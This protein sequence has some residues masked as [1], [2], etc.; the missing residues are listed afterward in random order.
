MKNL[1]YL[2]GLLLLNTSIFAQ[3]RDCDP[4]VLKGS[5][6]TCMLGL[7]PTQI[8][9]F[10]FEGNQWQQI[11][12][13]VDEMI[14]LDIAAPYG[15][16]TGD[17]FYKSDENVAWDVLFYADPNTYTGSDV[18]NPTVDADDE[19]AFMARDAGSQSTASNC[20]A[21]VDASTRCQIT[22]RDPLDNTIIGYVYLFRQTGGLRQDA[23]KDYVNYDFDFDENYKSIYDVCVFEEEG[24]NPES[25]NV[26]TVNYN[27]HYSRRWVNDELRIKAGNA[28]QIDILDHHQYFINV[29]ACNRNEV[30][31]SDGK[32]PIVAN[33]DG[34][35]RGIRSVMGAN[36]GTFTQLTT[37]F[38]E[39]RTENV[40]FYRLHPANGYYDVYD[41]NRNAIGML[42]Y[43]D[44]NPN[45][46]VIDGVRDNLVKDKP[47]EW[48]LTTGPQGSIATSYTFSTDLML[49]TEAQ[50]DA[51]QVEAFVSAYQSDLGAAEPRECT[52][53]MESYNSAGF[54]MRTKECTDNRYAFDEEPSCSPQNVKF[55]HQTRFQYYLTP[56]TT[57]EQAA[58]YAMFAKN[59]LQIAATSMSCNGAPAPTCSDG[60]QNGQ[61]T[62]VDCGG[63][64]CPACEVTPTCTDGIRNGQETGVDCGGPSCPACVVLPTCTDGIQN[65]QE[66]GV[67]C[68]GPACPACENPICPT[69][70]NLS[71]SNNTGTQVTLNWN[72]VPQA[73]T[74]N[75]QFRPQGGRTWKNRT[76]TSTSTVVT[77]L[78]S[79]T[80]YEWRIQSDCNNGS[81]SE[82]S[83]VVVFTAGSTTSTCTD[84]IQNG[85]ET[86]VD[87]GGSCPACPVEPTCSDGIQNGQETGVDCGG[88]DCTACPTTTCDVPT[89]LQTNNIT[90]TRATLNW[91]AV[92]NAVNYTVQIRPVGNTNW[93]ENT[94][95]NTF[96][97][98]QPLVNGT[99]YEWR[100][101][102]NCTN[103]TSNWSSILT[104]TAGNSVQNSVTSRSELNI[105][106]AEAYEVLIYPSPT[107]SILNIQTNREMVR[108]EILDVT[109]RVVKHYSPATNETL[110]SIDVS[111]LASGYY[112]TRIQVEGQIETLKFVKK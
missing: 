79:G 92:N 13:Q 89:G 68:G 25:S 107:T 56:S 72:P 81:T 1:V 43:N 44:Q 62:G 9:A 17:C 112:F 53:D 46:V 85:N 27:M 87:C 45:G 7:Q 24:S 30:T 48:E 23:N 110:V 31:F 11:P 76:V 35:I 18:T 37:I 40:M 70:T 77:G 88:T 90:T 33:I 19:I 52:G 96:L 74:Y 50:Y 16:T 108:I 104:F 83:P 71:I 82:W 3:T 105:N 73:N 36:S 100:V 47:N 22:V 59:P 55:F 8:V 6:S 86:G 5:Q 61:E 14:V 57:K 65:G 66:T 94:T 51:G 99:T 32:G 64:T 63:P 29:T 97:R 42:Y 41:L 78:K 10:S 54:C 103:G 102:T 69:P 80:M 106:D 101:R 95:K 49:G 28:N 58:R 75:L 67:D 84:G 26:S 34:P 111:A 4:V 20:P 39:C 2:I 15:P 38:T 91:N 98:V 12:V 109:G 93:I 60:I 21:G